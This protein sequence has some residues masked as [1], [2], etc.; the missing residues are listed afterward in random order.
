VLVIDDNSTNRKILDGM[1][2]QWSMLPRVVASGSE[3]FQELERAASFGNPF[4]L[5]LLDAQMPEIDG[6]TLASQIRQNAKLAGATIMMLTSAGQRG[7]VARCREL[8]IAVYLIKPIR[9]SELLEA[10]LAALG[11][12]P[13][14]EISATVITRHTLL[15]DRRKLKVLLAEDNVVNQRLAVRLLE[16]RGH[17][18]TVAADGGAALSLLKQSGF[19]LV[20][21]DVQMPVMD[22]FE[23][24]AAI[25]D[26]EASS[27]IHLPIIAMTAH[28]MQ[29]DLERCLAA[30]M[31]AY[32][33]KPIDGDELTAMVERFGYSGS[34]RN[35]APGA[36]GTSFD[37]GEALTRLQGDQELLADLAR[38][39]LNDYGNQLA[40]I[41]QSLQDA[42]LSKLERAAHSLKG[43]VSNFGAQRSFS[44]AFE[45]EKAAR[46][47]DL[48]SCHHLSR[49]LAA[50][51]EI[52]KT[53]LAPLA[54]QA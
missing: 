7:D 5:V 42:D 36:A 4:P 50:E 2:K 27:G 28:A 19:D 11:K 25:R 6:F 16:R 1:L 51:L 34:V 12:S 21:M 38:V 46:S 45:L 32:I 15:E 26:Q 29:G 47:N 53:E 35:P 22:G 40:D 3:G 30:G 48:E 44:V 37:L 39:F 49:A 9:K 52:L 13:A 17:S 18:V 41:R 8:G 10:M 33:A 20:L 23:A 31:D 43:S 24:T 14:N 54:G